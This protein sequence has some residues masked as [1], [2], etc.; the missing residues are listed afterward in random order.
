M[1]ELLGGKGAKLAEYRPGGKAV[2]RRLVDPHDSKMA[3]ETRVRSYWQANCA[4]C[5]VE[6][7]G[8]NAK[9]ELEWH[10]ALGDTRDMIEATGE[11]G[12][13]I[14]FLVGLRAWY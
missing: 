14:V 5:H 10:R 4:H 6:A 12:E 7:G 1:R 8:G 9:M 11:D 3:I 13:E 2:G